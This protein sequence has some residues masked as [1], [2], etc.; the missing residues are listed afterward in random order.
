MDR[1]D[2]TAVVIPNFNGAAYIR[3]C[4]DS[5]RAQEGIALKIIV[6]D[7]G[8]EDGSA[9][10]IE[11]EYPEVQ[12]IRLETN[13]G[14]CGAVNEGI[15]AAGSFRYIIL[16]NN[17]TKADPLFAKRLYDAAEKDE[18]IFSCQARMLSMKDSGIIDD[19]G[20]FYCAL[21]W[22]FSRGKGKHDG[23]RFRKSS[24]VFFTCAGAAIYRKKIFDQIGLF[25]EN[26]FAYLEDTDLG[27]RARIEGYRN[28]YEPEASVLHIG[29]AASGSIYNLF[30]VRNSSRNSVYLIAKNMPVLQLI[31][32]LPLLIP[33]FLIK[34][35]FFILKGYG[36]EY[37]LGIGKGFRLSRKGR[38]EGRKVVFRAENLK[39]YFVIQLELWINIFRRIAN[40][41][42]R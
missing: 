2:L 4:L 14:F 10:I 32:N 6:V 20:D 33:G 38:Q 8:S 34:W 16:L 17:D 3:G 30:K 19:A 37:A 23:K 22:A 26:H 35:V 18:R 27:W 11:K 21:G 25:D 12:L 5:L 31:L 1:K 7:N 13:R 36:R 41:F 40:F 24:D 28:V 29:S 42:Y 9:G 15:R 39:N